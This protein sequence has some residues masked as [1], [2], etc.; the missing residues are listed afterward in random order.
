VRPIIGISG[1]VKSEPEPLVRIKLNYVDAVRRAGG[2]PIVFPA[3][4]PDEVPALLERVD[5]VVLSGGDDI[6]VREFGGELHPK[7]ELM[8]PR[9]LAFEY[10]LARNLLQRDTP[11]LGICLG[12]QMLA[13]AAGAELHQHLPDA[14]Y[15]DLLEH[16]GRHEVTI[17]RGS[18]LAAILGTERASVVSSHHQAVASV[19]P[20]LHRVATAPDGVI[21]AIETSGERF[22][23]ARQWHPERSPDAAET[24]RLFRALVDAARRTS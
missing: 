1:D 19:P 22:L 6:D 16:R 14:G 13:F 11:T 9:R 17:E 24:E 5:G 15:D 20:P 3:C 7:A 8:H 18:R 23:V 2:I 10:A 21:E 12:M 4:A